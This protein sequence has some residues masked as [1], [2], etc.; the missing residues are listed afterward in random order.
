M[1]PVQ[2]KYFNTYIAPR[3]S[4][5]IRWVGEVD[6][7]QRNKLM[8]EALCLLHPVTWPEPFGLAMIEAMSCGCPVVAFNKGSIPEIVEHGK[9]GF[10]VTTTSEMIKA[11]KHIVKIDRYYC[12]A[13]ALKKFTAERMVDEY[14]NI[15]YK[16]LNSYVEKNIPAVSKRLLTQKIPANQPLLFGENPVYRNPIRKVA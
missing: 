8:S 5:Q 2:K 1:D 3:L 9:S 14:E 4:D 6:E 15:Y 13:Y 10:V 16:I 12:R 7:T 11:I